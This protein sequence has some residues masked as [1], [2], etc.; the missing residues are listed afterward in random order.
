MWYLKIFL[1][2]L[3]LFTSNSHA[4]VWSRPT[5]LPIPESR[6]RVVSQ[7]FYV[8][9]KNP[10]AGEGSAQNPFQTI[11]M[12]Q[13]AAKKNQVCNLVILLAQG[14]YRESIKLDRNLSLKSVSASTFILGSILNSA[15]AT[16]KLDGIQIYLSPGNGIDQNGGRL[17]MNN[18][19]V[20]ASNGIGLNLKNGVTAILNTVK[21][22]ENKAQ[23]LHIE[24][25]GT[26]MWA[27]HLTINSNAN[28]GIEITQNA[29]AFMND[30]LIENN[31]KVGLMISN[32]ARVNLQ[33]S[34]IKNTLHDTATNWGYNLLVINAG[35]LEIF[36]FNISGAS[37]IGMAFS[38]AYASVS[39]G[40]IENN[41]I[42]LYVLNSIDPNYN[43]FDCHKYDINYVNNVTRVS[44]NRLPLPSMGKG[45]VVDDNYMNQKGCPRVP[46]E[47]Y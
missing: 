10:A 3:I 9:Q 34:V 6:C 36:D 26:R 40:S 22:S 12:A 42:G 2:T 35:V 38:E 20:L 5:P 21:L 16:L 7:T 45:Q 19:N 30:V 28:V 41:P 4:E 47:Q 43:F 27:N 13:S 39:Q 1:L 29:K 33:Y 32:A 46:V 31:F 11:A 8:N 24:G 17:E 25:N 23:G 44:S 14:T 15:G 37:D 18:S